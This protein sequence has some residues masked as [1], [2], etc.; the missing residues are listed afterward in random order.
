MKPQSSILAA[1]F[2]AVSLVGSSVF[3][4]DVTVAESSSDAADGLDLQAVAELFKD[5]KD[6]EEFEK[7]LNDPEIGVN[8]LDLDDNGEVDFI[9]VMEE[10]SDDAR[11]IVLQVPL[12]ENEFQ[13]V[14]TIEV[15]KSGEEDYNMQIRGNEVIYGADYYIAPVQVH[16]HTWPIIP[17]M[18]RPVYHPYRS[19]FYFGFYPNWWHPWRPVHVNVYRTRTVRFTT[20]ATFYVSHTTRVTRVTKVNYR[21]SSSTLVRKQTRVTHGGHERTTTV[22]AGKVEVHNPKTGKQTTVKGVKKTTKTEHG[23]KTTVKGKK[24]T[25]HDKPKN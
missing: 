6:L 12:G 8:N 5:A 23:T 22:K 3:S 19:A 24:T 2:C 14:A 11:V 4:Q 18:F 21:A 10:A 13:D 7:S 17:W 20:R 15:E 25:H 9:R 1:L 16:V